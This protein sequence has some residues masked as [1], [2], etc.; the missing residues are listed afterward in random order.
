MLVAILGTMGHIFFLILFTVALLYY[1]R[2]VYKLFNPSSKQ[3][4]TPTNKLKNKSL[5]STKSFNTS[6]GRSKYNRYSSRYG[7][8]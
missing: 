7:R 8:Y 4:L 6:L 5:R 2:Y 3:K 1:F